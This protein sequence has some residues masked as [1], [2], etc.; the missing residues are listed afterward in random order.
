ML[1]RSRALILFI[2]IWILDFGP[3]KLP[4]LSRIKRAP[5]PID[6]T[7]NCDQF[8]QDQRVREYILLSSNRKKKQIGSY[9]CI[10]DCSLLIL[11]LLDD[12]VMEGWLAAPTL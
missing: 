8:P 1:A 10:Y 7:R 9:N 4:G 3:E 11:L 5:D 12:E 6:E 2:S